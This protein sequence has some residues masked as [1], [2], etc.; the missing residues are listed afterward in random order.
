LAALKWAE[1]SAGVLS[2]K[3]QNTSS[4]TMSELQT[5]NNQLTETATGKYLHETGNKN[6]LANASFE[7]PVSSGSSPSWTYGFGSATLETTKIVSGVSAVKMA[8]SAQAIN[9][10][11]DSTLYAGSF[12]DGLQGVAMMW[13]WSDS[14]DVYLCARNNSTLIAST[15]GTRITNCV[16]H[17]GNSKYALLKLPIILGAT[18]NGVALVSLTASTAAAKNITANIYMDDAFLGAADLKTDSV[19]IQTQTT[20][21]T[22]GS[23]AVNTILTGTPTT[24]GAGNFTISSGT[25]TALRDINVTIS[26]RTVNSTTVST[27][28]VIYVNGVST[29]IKANNAATTSDNVSATWAGIV[30]SGQTFYCRNDQSTATNGDVVVLST[31]T[32]NTQIY[33]SSCGAN[34]VDK[35]LATISTAGV[36]SKTNVAGWVTS[37]AGSSGSYTLTFPAG[38]FTTAPSCQT[39]ND[40]G[41]TRV[42][43]V[44]AVTTTSANVAT[45]STGITIGNAPFNIECSK[46]GADFI[47]TRNIVGSFNEM[48]TTPSLARPILFSV[49]TAYGTCSSSPCTLSANYGGVITSVTRSSAGNYV[50]NMSGLSATPNCAFT[51]ANSTS[52]FSPVC[53]AFSQSSS[54]ISFQCGIQNANGTQDVGLNI[55]CHGSKL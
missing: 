27:Q 10:Y 46:V 31:N 19:Q 49:N 4:V 32:T 11:Q 28:P 43:A 2:G 8:M 24:V 22:A 26:C 38:I 55:I 16:Q 42:S 29:G 7:N 41:N 12:A 20:K 14:P 13:V 30:P 40:D 3:A 15:D 33:S 18:N 54:A 50:M 53:Q 23:T 48:N 52:G 39:N 36:V 34:C 9:F 6:I 37:T 1:V 25:M 44:T 51:V 47:A 45:S 5:P 17:S 21:F 35:F